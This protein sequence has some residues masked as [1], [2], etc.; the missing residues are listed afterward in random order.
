MTVVVTNKKGFPSGGSCHRGRIAMTD[1]GFVNLFKDK[2]NNASRLPLIR[3]NQRFCHLPPRG[4][5]FVNTSAT[6]MHKTKSLNIGSF[7]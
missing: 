2:Y 6:S 1:E 3:Q 7:V 4:K 5:A